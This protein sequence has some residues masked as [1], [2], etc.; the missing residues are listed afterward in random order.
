MLQ[1]RRV[2]RT[3][4]AG[5]RLEAREVGRRGEPGKVWQRDVAIRVEDPDARRDGVPGQIGEKQ[6]AAVDETD[7]GEEEVEVGT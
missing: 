4:R 1:R 3:R 5:G 6:H 2:G 7:A